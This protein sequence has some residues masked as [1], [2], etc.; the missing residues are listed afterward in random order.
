M[1]APWLDKEFEDGPTVLLLAEAPEFR[2]RWVEDEGDR[3][4]VQDDITR[5]IEHRESVV[6]LTRALTGAGG[7]LAM[8]ADPAVGLLVGSVALGDARPLGAEATFGQRDA[9]VLIIESGPPDVITR[10]L[11]APLGHRGAVAYL[12]ATGALVDSR[13][14]AFDFR[15]LDRPLPPRGS[16]GDRR[17][18]LTEDVVEIVRPSAAVMLGS[19]RWIDEVGVLVARDVPVAALQRTLWDPG[20]RSD[21]ETFGVRF[22]EERYGRPVSSSDEP[23]RAR[24]DDFAS[25]WDD[26]LPIQF[27]MQRFVLDLF[28]HGEDHFTVS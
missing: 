4:A 28:G 7:R 20:A 1:S 16:L 22:L 26:G 9:P 3:D 24:G 12:D 21:L 13:S 27:L 14:L 10:G 25:E 5:S 15:E 17:Q 18:R 23:R 8:L 11:L 2:T 19:A 6:A